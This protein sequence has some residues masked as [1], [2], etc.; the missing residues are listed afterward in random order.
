MRAIICVSHPSRAR[1]GA[2]EGF[3]GQVFSRA[4]TGPLNGEIQIL[5]DL[6]PVKQR[7]IASSK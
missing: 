3:T 4:Q 1:D 5:N 6:I 2:K 7:W